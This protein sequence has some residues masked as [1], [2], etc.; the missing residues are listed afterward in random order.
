MSL[1]IKNSKTNQWEKATSMLAGSHKVADF[2]GNFTSGNVE[3][4]LREIAQEMQ[5]MQSH[6]KYIYQNGT[7]GGGSGGGGGSSMPTITIDGTADSDGIFRRVVKSDEDVIIYYFFNSP[8]VGN[9]TVRLA[10][11]DQVTDQIIKRGRNKWNAGKFPRGT[12]NLSI[13]VED[14]QGF[15][16]EPARIQIISGAIE[17]TSTFSDAKDLDFKNQYQSH[18][19]LLPR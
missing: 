18:I 3:G 17:V 19:E 14:Q 7:I 8:N 6:I 15:V 9:G 16:S 4:C 12:Y 11:G 2:D 10:N 13:S 1:K 5:K